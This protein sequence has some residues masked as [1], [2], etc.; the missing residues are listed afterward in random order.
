MVAEA[1]SAADAVRSIRVVARGAVLGGVPHHETR[2]GADD[3]LG[4]ELL[5]GAAASRSE[6]ARRRGLQLRVEDAV[7]L[8]HGYEIGLDHCH[9]R[10]VAPP[11]YAVDRPARDGPMDR[12][13]VWAV[14][15]C[16][17]AGRA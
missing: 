9:D 16:E 7:V 5:L 10:A 11:N 4:A 6:P 2:F 3:L 1:L 12:H 15:H 13:H 17:T 8:R 14:D